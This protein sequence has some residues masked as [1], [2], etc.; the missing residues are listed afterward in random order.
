MHASCPLLKIPYQFL[1][2]YSMITS[3]M[4]VVELDS[5][6]QWQQKY[7]VLGALDVKEHK[8]NS[9]QKYRPLVDDGIG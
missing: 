4:Y 8:D 2:M 7:Y 6:Q 5:I 1:E 3:V 9:V